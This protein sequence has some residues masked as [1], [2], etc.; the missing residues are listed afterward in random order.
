MPSPDTVKV[1]Y[2]IKHTHIYD[3]T[4]SSEQWPLL[5]QNLSM[6]VIESLYLHY[7]D[8]HSRSFDLV[9]ALKESNSLES[10]ILKGSNFNQPLSDIIRALSAHTKLAKL[11]IRNY[12][13]VPGEIDDEFMKAL[14][15]LISANTLETLDFSFIPIKSAL[16]SVVCDAMAKSTSLKKIDLTSVDFSPENRGLLKKALQANKNIH[17]F[18]DRF[19]END[20]K[21][22]TQESHPI[23]PLPN[24]TEKPVKQSAGKTTAEEIDF[25]K[26]LQLI[27]DKIEDLKKRQLSAYLVGDTIKGMQLATA[28]Q[29]AT[30]LLAGLKAAATPYFADPTQA[31]YD[32]FEEQCDAHITKARVVLDQH[33][34]WKQI[35][36]NIA[37]AVLGLGVLYLIAGGINKA[38]S[39]NF[40]FFQTD[41]AERINLVEKSINNAALSY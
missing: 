38:I 10:V 31:N 32:I 3:A 18:G 21:P 14:A 37:L 41:S 19:I 26:Q 25:Y 7:S 40:L 17:V 12:V 11:T 9:K 16:F 4:S 29:A 6:G 22:K 8:N 30:D 13:C 20:E 34:G 23:T 39:G 35:L 15:D 5:I 2:N 1:D 33:R 24:S 28:H 36:G 27:V